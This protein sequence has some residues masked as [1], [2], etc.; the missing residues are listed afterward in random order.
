MS[1]LTLAL[2]AMGGDHGPSITV[3]AALQALH[4]HP[5]LK[6]QL[7]GLEQELTPL[8]DK[9][10]PATLT[11][12]I[13]IHHA[14]DVVSMGDKPSFA[15]RNRRQ[16]SMRL[17]LN[18]VADGH[19][20]ACVSAGNTGALMSMAKFV[21]KTL[22][23][24]ERPALIAALPTEVG[25]RVHMLDLGANINC[26]SET[27]FQFALMGHVLAQQVEQIERP[28]IALLNIGE[29]ETKGN[30]QIKQTAQ[31]LLDSDDIHFVGYIEGRDIFTGNVDVVVCDGFVGNVCLKTCE[32]LSQFII[33]EFKRRFKPKGWLKFLL[34]FVLPTLSRM[35]K[36][37]NPDQ[38]N[39]ASLLGLRGIVVKSHGNADLKAFQHAIDEAIVEMERQVPKRIKDQLEA[40]LLDKHC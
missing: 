28:K 26:D 11:D 23:G 16:S 15:L 36:G 25:K 31:L 10:L 29:E 35:L 20:D 38:Y 6:I 40:A 37:M 24:I 2:D 27:L 18:A 39:G 22:P 13:S 1:H 8:L 34:P 21:L 32:G 3:P 7:F 12:R 9:S 5:H 14:D 33:K 17:A 19:A 4:S 30:D